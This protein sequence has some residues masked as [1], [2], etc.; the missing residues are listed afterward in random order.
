MPAHPERTDRG[1][2][3]P[4]AALAAIV[5]VLLLA[6]CLGEGLPGVAKFGPSR[7]T[8]PLGPQGGEMARAMQDKADRGETRSILIEG[9]VA[10]QSVLPPQGPYAQIADAI[11][12]ANKGSAAAELR[13]ARLKA[14]AKS[15]NWLPRI[16]PSVDL[17]SLGALAASILV[18]QVLFDNGRRK[19]E[20]DFAA[21]DV[22]VAAVSL[23]SEMNIRVH[24]GLV[25]YVTAQKAMRQASVAEVGVA[26]LQDYSRIMR[27]RVE[28]GLSDRSEERVIQQKVAEMTA[29]AS[30]DRQAAATAQA[31]LDAMTD[32]PLRGLSG[33]PPVGAAPGGTVPLSVLKAEGEGKRMVAEAKMARAGLL[34]GLTASANVTKDGITGGLRGAS[35]EGFGFG[36][37]ASLRA[38]EATEGVAKGRTDSARDT[39]A[40]RIVALEREIA[41]LAAREAEGA[42]VLRQTEASLR[43]F[44]EQYKLGRRPLMELVGLYETWARLERDQAA[45][46][47]DMALAR[48]RIGLENGVLVDGKRM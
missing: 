19:A 10:R 2:R 24:E 34:P 46:T 17:T 36:T 22:E 5:P 21:A 41:A 3:H 15:K 37:G 27:L 18:D 8:D 11:L 38:L 6:G 40:R 35:D 39:S 45:L 32:R 14:E 47:Y 13:V 29:I 9:L 12:T 4:A 42:S 48:L 30:S 26:K 25:H 16:G 1:G 20:R 43:M 44:T 7:A 28:G 23:S 33:L 31:E